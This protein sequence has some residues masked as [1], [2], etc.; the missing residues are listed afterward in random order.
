MIPS[1]ASVLV[2][3]GTSEKVEGELNAQ[4]SLQ[5]R[6]KHMVIRMVNSLSVDCILGMDFLRA[7]DITIDFG[8]NQWKSTE[9]GSYQPFD[10]P[11]SSDNCLI[12]DCAGL[13]ELSSKQREIIDN[14]VRK[15]VKPPGEILSA[16]NLTK[17]VIELTD[18]KPIRQN[19]RR[20]SKIRLRILQR[21]V[22][23]YEK[24]GIIEKCRSPWSSPP[25]LAP[26]PNGDWRMCID[27]RMVNKV[28]K[29]HVHPIPNIDAHLDSFA[30]ARYLTKLD[31]TSVFLQ[32]PIDENSRD[33][34]AFTVQER[35]QYRFKRMP[36]GMS[37]SSSTYQEMM[38]QLICSLPNGA[39]D[40]IFAYLD[41]LCVVSETFEEHVH[42]LTILLKAI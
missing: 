36:L 29:K 12:G 17:H 23:K 27:F 31:M 8:N 19:W 20:M 18:P 39:A 6:R 41:D 9:N 33:I 28:T 11:S 4:L 25:V 14:I 42:W 38:D 7:F 1:T 35:G 24:E 30:N 10:A 40:H 21:L 13:S 5:G 2:A 3:D 34:T 22:D 32:I 26:K 15:W 37:N 16:T